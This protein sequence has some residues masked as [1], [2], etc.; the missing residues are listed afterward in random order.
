MQQKEKSFRKC[1]SAIK[2]ENFD[3]LMNYYTDDAVLVI[4]PVNGWVTVRIPIFAV[5]RREH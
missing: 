2:E 5:K 3:T 1:D 4:K